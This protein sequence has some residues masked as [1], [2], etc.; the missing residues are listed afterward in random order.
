[1]DGINREKLKFK[2]RLIWEHDSNR[3]T[4]NFIT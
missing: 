3:K 1:M 4:V 2:S